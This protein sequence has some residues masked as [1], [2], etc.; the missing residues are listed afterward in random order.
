[1]A[2]ARKKVGG[3][4]EKAGTSARCFPRAATLGAAIF[5]TDRFALRSSF[6]CR[7][8][9]V[10]VLLS[11]ELQDWFPLRTS[12]GV[13]CSLWFFQPSAQAQFGVHPPAAQAPRLGIAV[14]AF[15]L[16]VTF[17]LFLL[18]IGGC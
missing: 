5:L 1:M 13:F 15:R 12:S 18:R 11:V 10:R 6:I 16:T 3:E 17:N 4:R 9:F 7:S 8:W 14:A 2:G